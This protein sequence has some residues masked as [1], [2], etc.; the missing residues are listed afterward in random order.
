VISGPDTEPRHEQFTDNRPAQESAMTAAALSADTLFPGFPAT[1]KP[2]AL[3]S[4]MQMWEEE[5]AADEGDSETELMV[6]LSG[7]VSPHATAIHD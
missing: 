2:S 6:M 1:A 5:P 3:R 7:M 4:L